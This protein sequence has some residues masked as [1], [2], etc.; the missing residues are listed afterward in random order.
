MFICQTNQLV[1]VLEV[2]S[3]EK[4]KQYTLC[5]KKL[6]MPWAHSCCCESSHLLKPSPVCSSFEKNT[7]SPLLWVNFTGKWL[8]DL[9]PCAGVVVS[10]VAAIVSEKQHKTCWK[11]LKIAGPYLLVVEW[12]GERERLSAVLT[13]SLNYYLSCTNKI[14]LLKWSPEHREWVSFTQV[15]LESV[16]SQISQNNVFQN[17]K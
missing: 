8:S 10:V 15:I 11:W 12:E 3:L 17:L 13:L 16:L 6:H 5:I 9:C 2:L 14:K 7:S 1:F 4:P